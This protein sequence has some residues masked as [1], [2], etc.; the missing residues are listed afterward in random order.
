M[1]IDSTI[2]NKSVLNTGSEPSRSEGSSFGQVLRES[3]E[4]VNSLQN[5]ADHGATQLALGSATELHQVMIAGEQAQL[6]L[7]L[8]I[9][10]RNKVVEAYQEISRMQI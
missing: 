9:A 3:L 4:R 10:V 1:R 6:A 7:Q 2:L 8:T 5:E